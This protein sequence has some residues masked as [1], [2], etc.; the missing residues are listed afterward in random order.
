MYTAAII[1][2]YIPTMAHKSRTA[3]AKNNVLESFQHQLLA[4]VTGVCSSCS[5]EE[6]ERMVGEMP[7]RMKMAKM[8]ARMQ[9]YVFRDTIQL[10]VGSG[11]PGNQLN[12]GGTMRL[13]GGKQKSNH[14]KWAGADKMDLGDQI[15]ILEDIW[16]T[17]KDKKLY[18]GKTVDRIHFKVEETLTWVRAKNKAIARKIREKWL[19]NNR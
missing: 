11:T 18:M 16:S 7:V 8:G 10:L 17:W 14:I 19:E 15:Y 5:R 3:G 2:W 1:E 6:L 4:M 9:K 12:Q 13:R